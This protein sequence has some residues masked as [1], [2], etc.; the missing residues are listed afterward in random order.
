MTGIEEL[1]EML[2]CLEHCKED[3]LV[4]FTTKQLFQLWRSWKSSE[5][6]FYPDQ[7]SE[8]QVKEALR[9]KAP[10]WDDEQERP[11]YTD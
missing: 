6:D 5:W 4:R 11:V 9:G 2:A 1:R 7:W 8:R 10:R 3:F